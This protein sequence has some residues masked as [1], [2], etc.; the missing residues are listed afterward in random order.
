[1]VQVDKKYDLPEC[2]DSEALVL[3]QELLETFPLEPS[4]NNLILG[5]RQSIKNIL[6][7]IDPRLLLIVGPCSIH[8][9][10]S[11]LEYANR[12]KALS[13]SISDLFFVVMRVYF[14]KPRSLCGWKGFSTDPHLDGSYEISKGLYLTRQLLLHLAKLELPVATEFLEAASGHYFGDLISWGCI[15]ARTAESQVHRQMASG[16]NLPMAFKN[17]TSGNV[18]VA[19]NGIYTASQPHTFMALNRKGKLSI[20][21]TTG[22]PDC[23]LVLRGGQERP[24]YDSDSIAKALDCLQRW[25][26]SS[27]ILIDCSHDNSFR[28]HRNQPSV[29]RSVMAQIQS[30]NRKIKGFCL[31][32]HLNE[33]KQPFPE[34]AQDLRYGISLT[35]SCLGWEETQELILWGYEAFKPIN[36][37]IFALLLFLSLSA[38]RTYSRVS[39]SSEYVTL[40]QLASYRV[41]TPDPA[42]NAP[43]V[44]QKVYIRWNLPEFAGQQLS[45]KLYLR[46]KDRSEAIETIQLSDYYGIYV[47]SLLNQE[48]FARQGILSYK[49][50]IFVDD[51]LVE[52][53]RHHMWVDLINF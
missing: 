17:N 45:C 16:L 31:E 4:Q 53:C 44:G 30:G 29:F 26:L 51:A 43:P 12:L 9:I 5:H 23:H 34:K 21:R 18:E 20:V 47:Y 38:C 46:F 3:P 32:S 40:E 25:N 36:K 50:E 28:D 11:T 22:N 41:G 14:E 24:N 39:I 27:G 6:A 13:Q 42:L 19:V 35:D 48:Y 2:Q 10:D 37:I 8:D 1:M 15:G 49:V 7:G 52:E 33:G